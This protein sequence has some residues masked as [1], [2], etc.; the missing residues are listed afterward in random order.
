[1]HEQTIP[2]LLEA[3]VQA[4]PNSVAHWTLDGE[5]NWTPT[6]WEAYFA[7]ASKLAKGFQTLGLAPR[8]NVGI[9]ARTAQTWEYIQMAALMSGGVIVGIDPHDLN[10]NV[11]EIASRAELV[12]LVVENS[13]LLA[14]VSDPVRGN[15]K[16]VV[17]I[18]EGVQDDA[19]AKVVP[20]EDLVKQGSQDAEPLVIKARENEPATIIFTSG[21]TG[22]PKGIMYTH[23]QVVLACRSILEAFNDLQEDSN[24]VC[25]LPLSNLFQRMINSC[26]MLMGAS[27]YFVENPREVVKYLPS[28][29]PHVFIG[30]P[31]FYEKLYDGI[32]EQVGQQPRWLRA[33]FE[34]SLKVGDA[35]AAALRQ[36]NMPSLSTRIAHS[37][38][39]PLVFKRLR[40]IMGNNLK[41]M[42]SGSAPMPRWLLER[43]HAMG[44]LILEAYGISENI[45]PVAAN[46]S[47]AVKFGTVGKP[48]SGNELKLLDDG[49]LLVKGPGVFAGYYG[50]DSKKGSLTSDDYLATGDYAH[51]DEEGFISLTGRKSEVFKTSTGR[52]IAPVGIEDRIRRVPYIEHAIAFGAGKKF[53]IALLSI[54]ATL[55]LDQAR[56][57]GLTVAAGKEAVPAGLYETIKKDVMREVEALPEYQRPAGLLITSQPF[58]IEGKELTGNLKLRRK[59]IAEKYAEHLEKFY[60]ELEEAQK[61]KT[62]IAARAEDIGIKLL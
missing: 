48:L 22:T 32:M 9:M 10:E 47:Q 43:F 34:L 52:R 41:Y 11:N 26:S 57:R 58:T 35:Y 51:I 39:D 19:P 25:W 60:G 13:H 62:G 15:F 59:N 45:I 3:R 17:S 36:K 23:E 29:N 40:Q 4:S 20:L 44:I 18:N 30:V 38:L 8:E 37:A 5:G 24:Q 46:R 21:T 2:G 49:E 50:D 28:I 12:G 1:M 7:E 31:R 27:T 61:Q 16:F 55:L 53:L 54:N 42:I 33:L 6:T 56:E 14:K